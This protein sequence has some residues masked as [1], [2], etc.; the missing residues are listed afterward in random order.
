MAITT[1][2]TF[3][4]IDSSNGSPTGIK[5]VNATIAYSNVNNSTSVFPSKS[6]YQELDADPCHKNEI[7]IGYER[8]IS[9]DLALVIRGTYRLV[10]VIFQMILICLVVT[11]IHS[12]N[13]KVA[14]L[15]QR[16]TSLA[17]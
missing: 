15:H 8:S 4:G 14:I 3:T 5:P 6:V 17:L 9:D 13:S 10:R 2:Y 1:Y 11:E 7:I 12:I 16:K